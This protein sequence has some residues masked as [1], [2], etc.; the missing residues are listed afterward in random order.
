VESNEVKAIATESGE[1][2]AMGW[3]RVEMGSKVKKNWLGGI[4]VVQHG[5]CS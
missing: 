2:V 4:S 1:V 3:G 5:N